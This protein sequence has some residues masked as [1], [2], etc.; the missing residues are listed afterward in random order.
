MIRF[1]HNGRPFDASRFAADIEAKAIA[2]GMQAPRRR[3]GAAASIVDPETGRHAD[4]FV[5]R[6]SGNRVAIRTARRLSRGF[7][8]SV[9]VSTQ[10][11]FRS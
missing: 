11:R 5:D 8:K 7:S 9:W 4:V 3:R 2:L 1:T 6:L 10:E